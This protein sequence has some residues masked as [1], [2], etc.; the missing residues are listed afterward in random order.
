VV[1]GLG[2][3]NL[4]ILDNDARYM[5]NLAGFIMEN[6][7]RRFNLHTFSA[8]ESFM[9]YIDETKAVPNIVAVSQ[10]LYSKKLKNLDIALILVICDGLGDSY[11]GLCAL[12]RYSNAD[13]L[14]G[15]I[16]K[17]YADKTE[18]GAEIIPKGDYETKVILITSPSGGAGKTSVSIG[19]CSLLSRTNPSVLYLNL[20]RTG[21]DNITYDLAK[22][23]KGMSD[24][25]FAIKS[26]LDK[27][28]VLLEAFRKDFNGE[29][30]SY[31]APPLFP[32]D[33]DE[34]SP[35]EIELLVE[36]IRS[37]G[38]Y[39]KVIIDAQSGFSSAN[40]A[41]ME[42]S[43]SIIIVI[44]NNKSEVRKLAA[45]K[46][47]MDRVFGAKAQYIHKRVLVLLN[48][49]GADVQ[50]ASVE[51]QVNDQVFRSKIMSLPQ[52]EEISG[53]YIAGLLSDITIEF[54][55]ALAELAAN[56][57]AI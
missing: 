29:R 22:H 43:D 39:G 5:E 31:Y 2:K 34:L 18:S 27:L 55:S 8:I 17:H 9:K 30:F 47:Q 46:A 13:S 41:L 48:K 19:L 49:T 54:G 11:D 44:N 42:L 16:L 7:S 36:K 52:C 40:K 53:S 35:G 33:L 12:E 26:R 51:H 10:G 45:M 28:P 23:S 25:I 38:I 1:F 57:N 4:V 21:I 15:G 20:D 24:I 3:L 56:T 50:V 37:L 6:Y 32:M 14:I